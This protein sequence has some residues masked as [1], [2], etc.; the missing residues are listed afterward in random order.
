MSQSKFSC[1]VFSLT[2]V[3]LSIDVDAIFKFFLYAIL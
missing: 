2:P 1:E 3:S